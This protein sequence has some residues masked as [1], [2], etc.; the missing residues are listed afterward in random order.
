MLKRNAV[1]LILAAVFTTASALLYFVHYL[2]FKDLHH[3]FIYMLGDI[4]F[5]PLEVLIVGLVL[6][7]ILS[8][9][10]RLVIRHKL[11]MLIG[12]FFSEVGNQ[13][14]RELLRSVDS[15]SQIRQRLNVTGKWRSSDFKQAAAYARTLKSG[16][17]IADTDLHSLKDFLITSR[18]FL[19]GLLGNPNL[20][21]E[22]RFSNLLWAILH[23]CEEL[24]ARESL[25]GLPAT[26]LAHLSSD[27]SRAFALLAVEWLAYIDHLRSNYPYLYSLVLR[28]HP[29]KEHPSPTVI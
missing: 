18:P 25:E 29:I 2:I 8:H 21:E 12:A 9:R 27:V 10:E 15:Q 26:D 1:F 14:F 11:N 4:A 22:E 17:D 23:V 13:L 5:L 19:L 28:I 16:V 3:I 6:D 24:E 20:L 7:R